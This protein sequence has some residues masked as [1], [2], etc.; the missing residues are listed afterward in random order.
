MYLDLFKRFIGALIYVFFLLLFVYF[1]D[2]SWFIA[3]VLAVLSIAFIEWCRLCGITCPIRLSVYACIFILL[4]VG[5][6]WLTQSIYDPRIFIASLA[7]TLSVY[8]LII[9]VLLI[10]LIRHRIRLSTQ[11][12]K[13]P[14]WQIYVVLIG[15]FT[16]LACLPLIDF[17]YQKGPLML[18]YFLGICI[19]MDVMAYISGRSLGRHVL[20]PE[21]SPKKTV[22][23]LVGGGISA[24]AW[25]ALGWHQYFSEQFSPTIIIAMSLVIVASVVG[26]LFESVLKRLADAKDSGVIVYGHGGM[27]DRIDSVVSAC[28]VFVCV[29]M[30]YD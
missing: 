18:M 7:G 14:A 13:T 9:T 28:P 24:L 25:V 3:F 17:I 20:C 1:L 21:I 4:G 23:G 5:S 29:L 11:L 26:D 27:L 16:L 30:L 10:Y 12:L 2:R 8:W 15:F 19:M 6:I 22:Q